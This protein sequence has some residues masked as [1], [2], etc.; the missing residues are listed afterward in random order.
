MKIIKWSIIIILTIAFSC[1]WTLSFYQFAKHP[2]R[3]PKY[4]KNENEMDPIQ[5]PNTPAF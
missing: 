3:E 4:I 1:L 5:S 2:T